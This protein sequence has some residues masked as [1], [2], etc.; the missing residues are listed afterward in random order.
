MIHVGKSERKKELLLLQVPIYI[1]TTS[2]ENNTAI[3][4]KIV[5]THAICP[6]DPLSGIDATKTLMSM[7]MYIQGSSRY[8]LFIKKKCW[9][10]SHLLIDNRLN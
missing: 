8:Q 2:F 3:P 10:R 5:N 7:Q 9:R 4:I 1:G 6:S